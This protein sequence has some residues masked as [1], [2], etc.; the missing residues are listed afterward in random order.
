MER[1]GKMVMVLAIEKAK[2]L[3]MTTIMR[4]IK[5]QMMTAINLAF[6]SLK[7]VIMSRATLKLQITSK[8]KGGNR[9]NNQ[10]SLSQSLSWMFSSS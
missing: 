4:I 7:M 3:E 2:M 8:L 9:R 5:I 10:W 6:E 1:V